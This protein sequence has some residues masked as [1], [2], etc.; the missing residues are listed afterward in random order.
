MI[1]GR[2]FLIY[3]ETFQLDSVKWKEWIKT[4]A[5]TPRCGSL[6]FK[7]YY[8]PMRKAHEFRK[9]DFEQFFQELLAD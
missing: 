5:N 4:R 7:F 9:I 1:F 3:K 6:A 8:I 2:R